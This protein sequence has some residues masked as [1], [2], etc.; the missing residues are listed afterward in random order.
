MNTLH[1]VFEVAGLIAQGMAYAG[2]AYAL[3]R[4]AH[5]IKTTDRTLKRNHNLVR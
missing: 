5:L 3:W 2:I 4:L 1:A